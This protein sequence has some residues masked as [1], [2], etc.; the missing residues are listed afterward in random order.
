MGGGGLDYY[1]TQL[2]LTLGKAQAASPSD[3][4]A[5]LQKDY[6]KAKAEWDAIRG[7]PRGQARGPDGLPAQRPYRLRM[8][9]LQTELM[10]LTD[11]AK[12]GQVAL[13]VR[14]AKTIGDT[15]I[16]LRGEAEKLGPVVPRGFLTAF[17]VPGA[18]KVNPRQSGRLELAQWLT[19]PRNPL[20]PRVIVNRVWQHLFGRGIVGTV[21]N[22]GVKG[23][24]PSHPELGARHALQSRVAV[25]MGRREFSI[26]MRDAV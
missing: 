5:Q 19:S 26:R 1:D 21:D 16:R 3:K 7:T 22:F 9:K 14:E 18:A 15:E 12:T 2:L 10:S 25:V 23:D 17:D 11:P 8:E 20:T 24:L 4:V 6:E 13:G